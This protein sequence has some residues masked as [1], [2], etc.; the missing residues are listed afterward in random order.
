MKEWSEE[1][2]WVIHFLVVAVSIE[3]MNIFQTGTTFLHG[4]TGNLLHRTLDHGKIGG[5]C[6]DHSHRILVFCYDCGPCSGFLAFF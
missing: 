4:L 2:V 5:G 6:L 3:S 1:N